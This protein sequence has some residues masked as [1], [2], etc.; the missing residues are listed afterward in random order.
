MSAMDGQWRS[1]S[2]VSVRTNRV[3][4]ASRELLRNC[5]N[6]MRMF[7]LIW[8]CE[9]R[10]QEL[11]L[12]REGICSFVMLN[13]VRDVDVSKSTHEETDFILIVYLVLFLKEFRNEIV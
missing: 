12:H 10:V 1:S 8:N 6:K 5:C 3:L 7:E 13:S 9:V 11:Y 4:Q 2:I